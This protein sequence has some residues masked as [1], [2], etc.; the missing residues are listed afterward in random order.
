MCVCV[1]VC[2][3]VCVCVCVRARAHMCACVHMC[4]FDSSHNIMCTLV[5]HEHI[6]SICTSI[7]KWNKFIVLFFSQN[8]NS[9]LH[10]A[11][12]NDHLQVVKL[13]IQNGASSTQCNNVSVIVK[14]VIHVP[15]CTHVQVRYMVIFVC[16]CI[17][18]CTCMCFPCVSP[19]LL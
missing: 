12:L 11:A 18:T 19:S 2:V 3:C 17:S 1:Y 4:V 10:L 8:G 16:L 5:I 7:G 9:P 13:L 14:Q 6:H 15:L